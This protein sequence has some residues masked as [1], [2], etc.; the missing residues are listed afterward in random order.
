M[1][2]ICEEHCGH[3]CGTLK[4]AHHGPFVPPNLVRFEQQVVHRCCHCNFQYGR[5]SR[6]VDIPDSVVEFYPGWS[7]RT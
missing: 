5:R 3:A 6:G 1:A 2:A 7:P 4:E